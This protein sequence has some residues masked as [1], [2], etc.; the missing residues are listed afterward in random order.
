VKIYSS[1]GEDNTREAAV[2]DGR[3]GG[4]EGMRMGE[5]GDRIGTID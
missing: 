5:G 3:R 2:I 1:D 4:M